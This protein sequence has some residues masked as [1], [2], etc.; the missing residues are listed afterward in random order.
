MATLF[1]EA[2]YCPR[3]LATL[4]P[5]TQ[6]LD[7]GLGSPVSSLEHTRISRWQPPAEAGLLEP[8]YFLS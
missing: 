7:S 3:S 2:L 4:P 5:L 1:G 8:G 6:A